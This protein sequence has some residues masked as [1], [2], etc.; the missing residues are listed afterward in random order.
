MWLALTFKPVIEGTNDMPAPR[1]KSTD[2][3]Q[4][5]ICAAKTSTIDNGY[6]KVTSILLY[7]TQPGSKRTRFFTGK[8]AIKL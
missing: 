6:K 8:R 7:T 3:L 1:R 5:L 4:I 2:R